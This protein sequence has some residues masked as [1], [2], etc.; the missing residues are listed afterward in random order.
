MPAGEHDVLGLDVAVDHAL[1]VGILER[2]GDLAADLHRLLERDLFLPVQPLSERLPDHPRHDV[3]VEPIGLAGIEE[4][5]DERVLQLGR[6]VDFLQEPLGG[7]RGGHVG[8]EHLDGDVPVVPEI[9]PQVHRRHAAG[10]ELA[11]DPVGAGQRS[12]QPIEYFHGPSGGRIGTGGRS[13]PSHGG[14]WRPGGS[15]RTGAR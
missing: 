7:E 5:K 6:D 8:E 1:A 10:A 14:A 2:L 4:G 11:L 12:L 13:P 3:V 15:G 9:A